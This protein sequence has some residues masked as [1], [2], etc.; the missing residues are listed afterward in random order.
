M[1][2]SLRR[3][4]DAIVS[5][6]GKLFS[7]LLGR[8][9]AL[10][11][12]SFSHGATRQG[13]SLSPYFIK[14]IGHYIYSGDT[15]LHFSAASHRPKMANTLINARTNVRATNRRVV[16][17]FMLQQSE[18]PVRP[19]GI[20]RHKQRRLSASSKP[21]LNRTRRIWTGHSAAPRRSSALRGCGTKAFEPGADPAIRNKNGSTATQL[22]LHTTGRGGSGS[23][24]ANSQQ[25]EILLLL[26]SR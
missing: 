19:H 1:D 15:A 13:P 11:F 21:A 23:S 10:A 3:L 22:A 24:E 7:K 17:R 26:Q 12:A 5:D 16:N 18:S 4:I 2:E 8:S 6:D 25:Q 14:E 9:S 20:R